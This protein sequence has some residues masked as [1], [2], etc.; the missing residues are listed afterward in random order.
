LLLPLEHGRAVAA[1]AILA[2]SLAVLIVFARAIPRPIPPDS[3]K[4][5]W[6]WSLGLCAMLLVSPLTEEHHLV[7]LLFPLLRLLCADVPLRAGEIPLALGAAILLGS[8]YSLDRF[9]MLHEGPLSL[10]TTGKLLGIV[11]LSWLLVRR[12]RAEES[13]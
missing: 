5:D 3:Q 13:R 11:A 2:A 9:P 6:A 12:L 4:A 7:V 8:R 1:G 10:L